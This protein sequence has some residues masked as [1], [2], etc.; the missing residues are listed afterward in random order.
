M[1]HQARP[2]PG[3]DEHLP[4]VVRTFVWG[5]PHQYQAPAPVGTTV[6]LAI[7]G[8]GTW[9][10]ARSATEWLLDEGHPANP[11]AA[12]RSTGDAAW[13]L[14]TGAP[15]DLRQVQLSG[16]PTLAQPL[17]HVRGIIV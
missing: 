5:F 11:A 17:L 2:E 12:L 7:D 1:T 16:D 8:V 4:L 13:R 6:G 3:A 14:L 10:L 9:T 15:Y